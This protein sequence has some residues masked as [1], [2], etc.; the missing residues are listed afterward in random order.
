MLETRPVDPRDTLRG[1][2]LRLNYKISDVPVNLFLSPV[3]K[4][5]PYGTKVFVAL[6]PGT[7]QFY[8]VTRAGTNEFTP[9]ANEIL[10][11]GTSDCVGGAPTPSMSNT[12]SRIITSPKAQATRWAN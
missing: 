11:R 6:A 1:D 8:E 10:L 7:N 4:D 2:Y 3:G 5:L 9:S 12:A